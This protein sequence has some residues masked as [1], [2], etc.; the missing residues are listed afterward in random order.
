MS[1]T[2]SDVARHAG[3]SMKTVSRVVNNEKRVA[4]ETR[5]KVL[6]AIEELGYVPNVWAQRLARGYSGLIGL[7]MHDATSAYITA[8]MNGMMD[9]G[10]TTGYRVSLY[11]LDINDPHQVAFVL[12]MATQ[13]RVEGFI[14]TPPCDNSP[15]LTRGLQEMKFPFVQLT[16]HE[17][18]NDCAWVSATDEQGSHEATRHLLELGHVRIGFIQGNRDHQASWDRLNGY[19]RA[20][21]EAGIKPD[22][23]LIKQ[24]TWAFESG[25]ECARDLL[26]MSQ[27]PTAI[28]AGNDE[29]AAGVIQAA[30]ER[31]WSCPEQIS[32]VG[33]DDVPLA[34][35]LCPPLTTVKQPIYE[36]ATTAM[37][38]LV[39]KIIPGLPVEKTVEVPTRLVVRHSTARYF[40]RAK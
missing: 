33:F 36:I 7:F 40:A 19:Y 25:L 14:F 16:P 32:V 37:S 39:E 4:E 27:P 5:R 28:M 21:H 22:E 13:R 6:A 23:C 26:S 18:C 35:Q 31:R 20:L 38:M 10:E 12:G 9:V 17:R 2:L 34:R 11:R 8:V 29:A 24:G 3:V 1:V 30:W 15:E